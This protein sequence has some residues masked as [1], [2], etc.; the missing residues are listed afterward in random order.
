MYTSHFGLTEIPFMITPDPRYLF[1]GGCHREAIAHLLYGIR[2]H[3]GFVQLTGEVGTGKTTLCRALLEQLPLEVDVAL[4]WNPRL[5]AVE[6][7]AAVCDE[8]RITYSPGMTSLKVLIDAL[9]QH[10]LEAHRQGRR[11]VLIIDEAQNLTTDVLEEIRLLTNLETAKEKLLQVILIGQPELCQLLKRPE[12]RQVAQ[13]ITARYHLHAFSAEESG[14]YIGHRVKTAGGGETLFTPGALRSVHRWAGGVPRLINIL[15][16]RALLGT[17]VQGNRHVD[18]RT[19]W[20]ATREVQGEGLRSSTR[21]QGLWIAGVAVLAAALSG[22]W[23][24]TISVGSL[25]G[26]P[27]QVEPMAATMRAQEAPEVPALPPV[28]PSPPLVPPPL[29]PPPQSVLRLTDVLADPSVARD[30]STALMSLY[31]RWG[32]DARDQSSDFDC[33]RESLAGLRCLVK[34]GMWSK[35]RRFNLPA[36]LTLVTADGTKHYATLTA[37]VDD[38]AALDFS[39]QQFT[40]PL[41]QLERVWDGSFI[42]L[43]KA[44]PVRALPLVSGMR[45]RDVEWLRQRL[46]E[47]D[48]RPV[49]TRHAEVF[50]AELAARVRRFQRSRALVSD[51]I[52]GEET[53]IHLS[54]AVPDAGAPLLVAKR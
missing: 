36:I 41:S 32:V 54:T 19:V 51:G 12:L 39:G 42:V 27:S 25:A 47:L 16:D 2:E 3:G 15:C 35:L 49:V 23:M 7:L 17:Y 5:T 10:L 9:Y 45:G 43:W 26:L 34:T 33:E 8:L 13:R 4:L 52:V 21:R 30:K 44:P 11:T 18:A 37:L 53:L 6:L 31:G 24:W 46:G 38:A 22:V 48:G 14:A 40:F 28:V 29:V 20:Q 50:D 1:M